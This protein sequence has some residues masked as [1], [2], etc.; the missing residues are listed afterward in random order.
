MLIKLLKH[1]WAATVKL[2]LPLNLLLIIITVIG[3]ILLGTQ[4]LKNNDL[5]LFTIALTTL[6]VIALIALAVITFVFLV[7]RFYKNLFK[8][9]VL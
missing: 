1:E 9:I 4:I 8:Q 7:I 5:G 6:Y 3:R 2:L